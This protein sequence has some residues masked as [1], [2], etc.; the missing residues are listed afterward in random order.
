MIVPM[1]NEADR[2]PALLATW[3]PV[4]SALGIDAV[5][6]LYDDG[7]TDETPALLARV[8]DGEPRVA[9]SRHDNRGHGPTL[10][11]AYAEVAGAAWVFQ[12]D[13]DDAIG[14]EVFA[15]W[16]PARHAYDLMTVR[17]I[18]PARSRLRRSLTHLARATVRLRFGRGVHDVNAPY[19]LMRGAAFADA[20][21]ALRP[22]SLVPEQPAGGG[23][24]PPPV[25]CPRDAGGGVRPHEARAAR[26][27]AP[28]GE[29]GRP[30]WTAAA[31]AAAGCASWLTG[32]WPAPWCCC[33]PAEPC[34]AAG[35][36]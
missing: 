31:G 3:L 34:R 12:I 23:R 35:H 26:C 17:R 9:A 8:T 27:E 36:G 25:A 16:W 20:W 28:L 1:F 15:R 22:D 10:A 24:L 5:I 19:R 7:S 32:A 11:R 4:L 14:P 13:A 33:W 21:R 6:H 30:R 18:D 29:P 2:I